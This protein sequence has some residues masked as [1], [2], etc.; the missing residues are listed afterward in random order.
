MDMH[1]VDHTLG[2]V[3]SQNEATNMVMI[4]GHVYLNNIKFTRKTIFPKKNATRK[5]DEFYRISFNPLIAGTPTIDITRFTALA[6]ILTLRFNSYAYFVRFGLWGRF[7]RNF[8]ILSPYSVKIVRITS[9]PL[10]WNTVTRANTSFK[11]ICLSRSLV[12]ISSKEPCCYCSMSLTLVKK[13]NKIMFPIIKVLCFVL[14]LYLVVTAV[15]LLCPRKRVCVYK[16]IWLQ[17][18]FMSTSV[19]N[20]YMGSIQYLN[21]CWLIVSKPMDRNTG[22]NWCTLIYK[23]TAT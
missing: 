22:Y 19:G 11:L 2:A 21:L 9:L 14:I 15:L 4:S 16:Q 18:W 10:C 12:S 23:K 8:K 20:I 17:L 13:M 3:S 7:I 5:C 6:R 1:I